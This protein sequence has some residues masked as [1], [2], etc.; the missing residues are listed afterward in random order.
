MPVQHDDQEKRPSTRGR[1]CGWGLVVLPVLVLLLL[2]LVPL[3]RPIALHTGDQWLTLESEILSPSYRNGEGYLGG[4]LDSMGFA[5][6]IANDYEIRGIGQW[7]VD[8]DVRWLWFN[9]GD[10]RYTVSWFRGDV[11]QPGEVV[12]DHRW[13]KNAP[14]VPG[15]PPPQQ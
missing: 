13:R 1:R 3:V 8:G 12:P 10:W 14:P 7:V 11:I 5:G 4:G 6:L 2:L 15:Y 9:I